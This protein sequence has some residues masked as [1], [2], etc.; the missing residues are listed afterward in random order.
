MFVYNKYISY[1]ILS[2]ITTLYNNYLPFL[3]ALSL[4]TILFIV[5]SRRLIKNL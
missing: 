2:N 4:K 5:S 1:I 3:I